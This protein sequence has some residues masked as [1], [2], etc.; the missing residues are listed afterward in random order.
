MG[1]LEKIKELRKKR[2]YSQK[3]MAEQLKISTSGYGKI[4]IGENVLS[5]ERFLDICRILK[6]TSYNQILPVINLDVAT[7]IEKV[8]LTGGM[9]F[10]SIRSNTVYMLRL[11]DKLQESVKSSAKMNNETVI[12]ELQLIT[13]Y[14]KIISGET[15]KNGINFRSMKELIELID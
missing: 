3:Y 13:D 12:N 15:L 9:S 8:I 5:V 2:G 7:E 11:I 4:E 10:E 6:V 14:L 1:I